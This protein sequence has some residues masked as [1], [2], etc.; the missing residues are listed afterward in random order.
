MQPHDVYQARSM[1]VP[2]EVP[3]RA[4]PLPRRSPTTWAAPTLARCG[5][6]VLLLCSCWAPAGLLLGSCWAT[7]DR[8][9]TVLAPGREGACVWVLPALSL[10]RRPCCCL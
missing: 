6:S 7:C 10:L 1:G 5:P 9:V 2:L 4:A 3:P 8:C